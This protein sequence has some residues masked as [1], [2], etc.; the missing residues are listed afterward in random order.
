VD[1][2]GS[3]AGM[4]WV[5]NS[6]RVP[7][8]V[9]VESWLSFSTELRP[10]VSASEVDIQLM[11]DVSDPK[12]AFG[13][14]KG[15]ETLVIDHHAVEDVPSCTLLIQAAAQPLPCSSELFSDHL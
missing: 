7:F 5:L 1:A 14:D 12:R 9:C 10:P 11:L 13:Y 15:L 3:V 4:S 8:S 2:L 6:M